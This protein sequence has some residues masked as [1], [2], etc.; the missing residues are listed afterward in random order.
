MVD[1]CTSV[2]VTSSCMGLLI[3]LAASIIGVK[4]MNKL[5]P[6]KNFIGKI[7]NLVAGYTAGAVAK[8]CILDAY[9]DGFD[10]A[11]ESTATLGMNMAN[12]VLAKFEKEE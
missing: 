9:D 11:I 12:A 1:Y 10:T 3:E 5:F 2:Q 6:A 4:T 8:T 7:G